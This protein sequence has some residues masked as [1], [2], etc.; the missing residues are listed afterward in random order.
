MD[1]CH[2]ALYGWP[3]AV[4]ALFCYLPPRRAV[5][6]AVILGTMF[7]PE[8]QIAA[9]SKEAPDPNQFVLLILKFTKPNAI[10]FAALFGAVLFDFKTLLTFR[11]RWFDL[12]MLAWCVCPFPS[13]LG[14]DVST[15]DSFAAMRDQTLIWGVPYFLGRV[16]CGDLA[17]LRDLAT[18][19][20]LGG[21]LYL[22]PFLF[23]SLTRRSLHE[24]IYGFFP[25]DYIEAL[26][27]GGFRPVVF[28]SHGIM[29]SLWMAAA[30]LTAV[31]L[32]WTGSVRSVALRQGLPPLPMRW[33][34]AALGVAAPLTRSAGALV[35]GALGL[36]GLFQLRWLRWP[37]VLAALLAASP[38]YI[39][40][41]ASGVLDRPTLLRVTFGEPDSAGEANADV[42]DR[43]KSFEFR[44]MNEDV[45]IP[46]SLENAAFGWGD[47]GVVKKVVKQRKPPILKGQQ[48]EITTDGLWII[49][50]SSYGLFGLVSLWTAML[51]PAA[52]YLW[53]YPSQALSH[54]AVAP[55]AAASVVVILFMIDCL[56]NA[57]YNPVYIL[58][59]GGVAGAAGA[60]LPQAAPAA[61]PA[62]A[63][64]AP[65][66]PARVPGPP[67]PG[68][69]AR[70]R[71]P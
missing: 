37:V 39:A 43:E 24:Q 32:W 40:A 71:R 64:P 55:G 12:P 17:G 10:C 3:V 51:L 8:V 33:A 69:L 20:V 47:T 59:A 23:E 48:Y 13:D 34:T 66:P 38:L 54:A 58:M 44:L 19:V 1:I 30:A 29:T 9:V 45:L 57:M 70:R 56:L 46:I 11:P 62:V 26:R 53:S 28:M 60:A 16:Y 2:V 42:K 15:Y 52:R 31:W 67:R 7:L 6:A 63:R 25:G 49:T 41:R 65:P 50:L 35:L 61:R 5:V 36:A 18:G 27:W 4:V 14:V 68:V 22:P 21:L